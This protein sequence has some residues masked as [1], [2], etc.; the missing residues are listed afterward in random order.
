MGSLEGLMFER[1][2]SHLRGK[3]SFQA[4]EQ[5]GQRPS[6]RPALGRLFNRSEIQFFILKW[7]L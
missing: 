7:E 5:Q 2:L 6:E 3:S 4:E 1:D